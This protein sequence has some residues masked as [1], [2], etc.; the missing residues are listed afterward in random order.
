[1]FYNI[2][3]LDLETRKS[4]INDS[5]DVSYDY[6]I[7]IL[8]CNISWARKRSDLTLDEVMEKVTDDTHFVFIERED[9]FTKE[10]HGEV[11]F[12]TLKSPSHYLFIYMKL[13]ELNK[14][15]DKYNLKPLH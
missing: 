4:V 5:I 7:D 12:A 11:G 13:D 1:M 15:K 10:K 14:L 9:Y 6:H 8:D 2:G 3:D